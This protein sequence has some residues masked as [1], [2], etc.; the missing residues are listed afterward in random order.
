MLNRWRVKFYQYP[1][2]KDKIIIQTWNSGLNKFYATREFVVYD[3]DNKEIC[4][5]ST[6][7]IFLDMTKKR[8]L[9]VPEKFN[10]IYGV[11]GEK[12]LHDFYDFKVEFPTENLMDFSVRK[13]DIDY[14]NHVNNVKYLNWML[15]TIPVEINDNYFFGELDILYK[16]EVTLGSLIQS[17]NFQV[18]EIEDNLT[19]LH[20][21]CENDN[22]HAYGRT[23]W[24]KK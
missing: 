11:V 2:V 17:S 18:E 19:F 6:Q 1:R 14:N 13:S 23:V 5:A 3:E 8:P 9:R 24:F 7:W 15:E 12:N 20:K 4:K 22:I 16:K 10:E 21:I